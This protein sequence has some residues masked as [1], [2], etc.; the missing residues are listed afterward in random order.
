MRM[1]FGNTRM[2]E[3]ARRICC[4]TDPLHHCRRAAVVANREGNDFV[5][6]ECLETER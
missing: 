6:A 3:I 4:H 1:A 5:G 2:V